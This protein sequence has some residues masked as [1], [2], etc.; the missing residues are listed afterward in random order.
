MD[1]TGDSP[2]FDK[3]VRKCL[4]ESFKKTDEDFLA[5]AAKSTPTWKDGTTVAVL[6]VID[7]VIFSGN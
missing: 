2:H 7:N 6:L 3:E 4:T 5:L 1:D